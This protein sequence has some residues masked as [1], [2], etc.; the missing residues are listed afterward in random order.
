VET[1]FKFTEI[2]GAADKEELL[3]I[4]KAKQVVA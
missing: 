1:A 4:S 3:F 2:F